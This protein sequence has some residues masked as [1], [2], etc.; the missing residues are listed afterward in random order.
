MNRS[1]SG[2]FS[3]VGPWV[4]YSKRIKTTETDD[5]QQYIIQIPIEQIGE[6]ARLI[7]VGKLG[8]AVKA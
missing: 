7:L 2:G 5:Q 4:W 3:C 1:A 6:W 8:R